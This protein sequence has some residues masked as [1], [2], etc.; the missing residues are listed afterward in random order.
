MADNTAYRTRIATEFLGTTTRSFGSYFKVYDS[1]IA[2]GDVL[3]L[4][5]EEPGP[6]DTSPI[7]HD[8]ILSAAK[9]LRK[10]PNLT[11]DEASEHLGEILN[12]VHSAYQLRFAVLVVRAMLMLDGAPGGQQ[13][14]SWQSGE[15]FVDFVSKCCPRAL[16]MT[17]SIARALEDQKSLKAWKLKARLGLTFKGTDNLSRHLFLDP[18]HPEGLTLY[19]FHHTSFLKAQLERLERAGLGREDD[20]STCLER[21]VIFLHILPFA[22]LLLGFL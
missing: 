17:G 6:E 8:D 16:G 4:Q 21:N 2:R 1:L 3:A 19:I 10:N 20:V 18:T 12:G 14:E 15:R 5:V 22:F 11:L 7:T 9:V 13:W